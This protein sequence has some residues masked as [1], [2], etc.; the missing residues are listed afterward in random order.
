MNR[1]D[2]YR[3][4]GQAMQDIPSFRYGQAVSNVIV[5][6]HPNGTFAISAETLAL[7]D[8]YDND[9]N[10]EAFLDALGY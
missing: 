4:A 5:K 10:V 7:T 9:D 3:L 6:Y 1:S 2:V 8:P